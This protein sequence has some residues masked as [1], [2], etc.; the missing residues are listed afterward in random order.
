MTSLDTSIRNRCRK[1]DIRVEV[2]T[3]GCF[4]TSPN[5]EEPVLGEW[6]AR[7]KPLA[8]RTLRVRQSDTYEAVSASLLRSV[9]SARTP[10]LR[11]DKE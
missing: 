3:E 9:G 2:G 1:G 8:R 11:R 10:V 4:A 5:P 6:S 7:T